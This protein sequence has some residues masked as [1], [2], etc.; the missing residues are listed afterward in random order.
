MGAHEERLSP[1]PQAIGIRPFGPPRR[2]KG[3]VMSIVEGPWLV[4][5]ISV[6]EGV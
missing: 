4:G 3:A 1:R 5:V 2:K 6:V